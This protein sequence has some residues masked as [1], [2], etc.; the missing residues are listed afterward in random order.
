MVDFATKAIL[1]ALEQAK[2]VQKLPNSGDFYF[3]LTVFVY[4]LIGTFIIGFW[5]GKRR[6]SD[7]HTD[8]GVFLLVPIWPFILTAELFVFLYT[9]GVEVSSRPRKPKPPKPV[10]LPDGP[11]KDLPTADDV[12]RLLGRKK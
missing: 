3:L 5:N 6:I 1:K 11:V 2:Q 10:Y 12:S 7:P 4:L 8:P 9:K